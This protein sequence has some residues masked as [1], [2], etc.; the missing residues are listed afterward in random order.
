MHCSHNAK[1]R[2][3]YVRSIHNILQTIQIHVMSCRNLLSRSLKL[4]KQVKALELRLTGHDVFV[5]LPTGC[6]NS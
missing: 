5:I 3:A 1:I 4:E 6:G 2:L